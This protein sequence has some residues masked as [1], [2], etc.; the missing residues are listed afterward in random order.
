[1]FFLILRYDLNIQ[2]RGEDP[3]YTTYIP[4]FLDVKKSGTKTIYPYAEDNLIMF[5]NGHY[6]VLLNKKPIISATVNKIMG[7]DYHDWGV[8]NR[9]ASI[10]IRKLRKS[11]FTTHKNK[12]KK[13]NFTKNKKQKMRKHKYSVKKMKQPKNKSK[14]Y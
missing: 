2:L 10:G 12:S 3:Y 14:K 4:C 13:A 9:G 5:N 11:K 8:K 6:F 1:M 7:S